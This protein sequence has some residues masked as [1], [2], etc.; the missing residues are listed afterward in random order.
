[1]QIES[2]KATGSQKVQ[3][4]EQ[5]ENLKKLAEKSSLEAVE[6]ST[7][8]AKAKKELSRFAITRTLEEIA[9]GTTNEFIANQ[10]GDAVLVNNLN[11]TLS[12]IGNVRESMRENPSSPQIIALKEALANK[13]KWT[14]N[15]KETKIN[16]F[17]DGTMPILDFD[18]LDSI[19]S[20]FTSHATEMSDKTAAEKEEIRRIKE[21]LEYNLD[22]ANASEGKK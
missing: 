2:T 16:E 13:F 11:T 20:V 3:I 10:D 7:A 6:A 22:S 12:A 19:Q 4:D 1:M 9:K 18:T 15:E 8:Q 14:E 21:S 17:I 5:I